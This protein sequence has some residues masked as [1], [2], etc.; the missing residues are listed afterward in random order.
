MTSLRS[1]EMRCEDV[2][3]CHDHEEDEQ[4]HMKDVPEPEQTLI[5]CKGCSLSDRGDMQGHEIRDAGKLLALNSSRPS[6][7]PALE[8]DHFPRIGNQLHT[9]DGSAPADQQHKNKPCEDAL[10]CSRTKPCKLVHLL[11]QTMSNGRIGADEAL[12]RFHVGQDLLHDRFAA[13]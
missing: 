13:V 7:P 12:Q 10:G 11:E 3:D 4:G 9:N 1:K 6:A 5:E 2:N 8:R